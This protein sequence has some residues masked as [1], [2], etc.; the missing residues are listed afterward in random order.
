VAFSGEVKDTESGPEAFTENSKELNPNLK[1]RDIREA[2]KG[3]EYQILLVANKFQTGF[4]QPLLCGMYVDKKLAGIQAVQTLSRLNRAYPGK[5]TT[6][7]L[8]FVNESED[9]LLAFK[10][11]HTTAE[12]A[13]VTDK[14]LVLNLRAKLDSS[15][16]YADSEVDRVAAVEMNPEAR[17]SQ[18]DAAISPVAARL[19]NR[20]K[21]AR[22]ALKAAKEAKDEAAIKEAKDEMDSLLLFRTDM[23]SFQRLY[24][25]LSQI[26]DY[27]NTDIE[28]RSMFYRRLIP[29]LEF[30]RER[31]GVDLSKVVLTH[32][33]LK[34]RGKQVMDLGKGE[35]PKL[36]PVTSVG[37]GE[38]QEKQQAYLNEIIEKLNEIFG[39]DTTDGDQLVYANHVLRGKL[40]ESETLQKQAAGNSREQF[41]TS[42]DF[43]SEFLNAIIDALDAHTALSKKALDSE[44]IRY[45][46]KQYL[47]G[48]GQLWEALRKLQSGNDA[49]E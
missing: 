25:F 9:I 2:F 37:S 39:K 15:G 42:P 41:S 38:V 35:N 13:N 43:D 17:Q 30:G 49:A 45:R 19:L 36:Q 34:P 8:D 4:D 47:L 28:K 27:G 11:Y 5:D 40:L 48:P 6:Y 21:A 46:L 18:L 12:L 32:H 1:G 14:N 24:A 44:D 26:F 20:Y 31:E 29:L 10:M 3:D 22:S 23:V 7:V 16:F 33:I